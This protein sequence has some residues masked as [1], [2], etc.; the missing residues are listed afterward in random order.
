MRDLLFS[1]RTALAPADSRRTPV[2]SRHGGIRHRYR[3]RPL[4]INRLW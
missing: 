1:I 3:A 4:P 2:G